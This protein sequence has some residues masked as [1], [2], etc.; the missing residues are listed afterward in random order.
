[1]MHSVDTTSIPGESLAA[2]FEQQVRRTPEAA[3]VLSDEGVLTYAALNLRANQ[4]AHAL[5]ARGVGPEVRVGLRMRRGP[6]AVVAVLGV[7]KAGGAYVPVDPDYP[8]ERRR[9]IV[10]DS[11]MALMLVDRRG[12]D[13]AEA[14]GVPILALDDEGFAGSLDQNLT[15]TDGP[16]RA[17]RLLYILYTSGSTGVPKG[18]CATHGATIHR[19][20]WMWRTYPFQAG[21]V[22]AHRTT[23]N[24]VDS[25]WEM[26]G[27]LLVGV[28]LAVISQQ[29]AGDPE[30]LL[31]VCRDA[32]VTRITAVPS[33]LRAVLSVCPRLS[34]SLPSARLWVSSGERLTRPLYEQFRAAAPDVLLLNLYGSTEVAGDVTCAALPP[35]VVL[36]EDVPIGRPIGDARVLVL[37]DERRPVR[38]GDVGEAYVGGPALAR[39]Y[40]Q[41]PDEERARFLPDPTIAGERLFRTGD[42]VRE[43]AAGQL[44]YVGRADHQIKL[45]GMRIEPEEI[46]RVLSTYRQPVAAAAVVLQRGDAE[47]A[48]L[49]A[50][51]AP[52]SLDAEDLRRHAAASL[53]TQMVPAR[54]VLV[55]ELPLT[56]NGKVDRRLLAGASAWR[57]EAVPEHSLPQTDTERIVARVWAPRLE[58][59]PIARDADFFALGGDSLSAVAVLVELRRRFGLPAGSG[60]SSALSTIASAARWID[61]RRAGA[62]PSRSDAPGVRLAPLQAEH[63]EATARLAAAVFRERE[64]LAACVE[65]SLAEFLPFCRAVVATCSAGGLSFVATRAAP[66]DGAET[67]VGFCLAHDLARP[68]DAPSPPRLAPVLALLDELGRCYE[69]HLGSAPEPGQVAE[70]FMSGVASGVDGFTVVLALEQASL[71]AAQAQGYARAM[72]VCTH[73]VTAHLALEECG[74]RRIDAIRYATYQ[75]A[76]AAIFAAADAVHREAVL[77]ERI[78][79]GPDVF[80]SS[81]SVAPR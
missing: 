19:F 74:F 16:E 45:R 52:A 3:A 25:V 59:W 8:E 23:L 27:P 4:V 70:L 30:R 77:V 28:P 68:L 10:E 50:F 80:L 37:D 43:G 81:R 72:A 78:L 65:L 5:A 40:H 21:E 66:E 54:I 1:M 62:S 36:D 64:P 58:V 31:A 67:V 17:D 56:P 76:G 34:A 32:G 14:P 22:Q 51:V 42:R 18:V 33:L 79:R 6:G 13:D 60:G 55:D 73:R 24:F 15:R 57:E 49:C 41:R 12:Q 9:F 69:R 63:V 71:A 39:G 47:N 44:Y 26:L 35:G 20:A 75:A 46:E 61:Q 29:D 11:G 7:L 2:L 38:R 53:P 48:R